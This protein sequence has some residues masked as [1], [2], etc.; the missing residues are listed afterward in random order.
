MSV[1]G[2]DKSGCSESVILLEAFSLVW[3]L[4]LF[5]MVAA[6]ATYGQEALSA[7]NRMTDSEQPDLSIPGTDMEVRTWH[8]KSSRMSYGD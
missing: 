7:S 1:P 8:E 2:I 5:P 6:I 3:T 4:L